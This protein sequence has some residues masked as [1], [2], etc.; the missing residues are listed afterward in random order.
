MLRLRFAP[1]AR[2]EPG[3]IDT[4][5]FQLIVGRT[6]QPDAADRRFATARERLDVIELQ[7]APLVA[8]T[9]RVADERATAAVALIHG[10]LHRSRN[11]ALAGRRTLPRSARL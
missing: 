9:A 11:V 7:V 3:A 8:A 5:G 6:Q 2:H 4:L 1:L 10:A